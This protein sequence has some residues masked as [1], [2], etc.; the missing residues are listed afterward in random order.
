MSNDPER[1]RLVKMIHFAKG[2]EAEARQAFERADSFTNSCISD[3]DA[4][5]AKAKEAG[6]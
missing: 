5:D 3:L 2:V 4:Y 6:K 1:D